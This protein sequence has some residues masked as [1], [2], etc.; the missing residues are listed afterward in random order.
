M[1]NIKGVLS[2]YTSGEFP[3]CN[4]PFHI[5]ETASENS[6]SRQG[7]AQMFHPLKPEIYGALRD[8]Y[9]ISHA[10]IQRYHAAILF[11]RSSA[12]QVPLP[13]LKVIAS[14]PLPSESNVGTGTNL[15]DD[16]VFFSFSPKNGILRKTTDSMVE[17]ICD[18]ANRWHSA[19]P[20]ID[21]DEVRPNRHLPG[22]IPMFAYLP[23][24]F[25]QFLK[26]GP[27][28]AAA[29]LARRFSRREFWELRYLF[30]TVQS[31]SDEPGTSLGHVAVCVIS[32]ES[33]TIDFLCS[34]GD[35]GIVRDNG[36][37]C[38]ETIIRLLVE[39]LGDEPPLAQRFNPCDWKL[40]TERS[41]L[42]DKSKPDCGMYMI[43]NIMCV[44]FGWDLSYGS[45]QEHELQCR[46][47]RLVSD[48]QS[49]GFKGYNHA[50]DADNTHYYPLNDIKPPDSLTENFIPILGYPGLMIYETLPPEVYC[51]SP[52]YYGCPDKET[53]Y[54]HCNRNK[55]F[56]PSFDKES[57]SGP[58]ISFAKLLSWVE[59]YDAARERDVAPFPRPYIPSGANGNRRWIP[60]DD[61]V[62]PTGKLW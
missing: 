25:E 27:E 52:I 40:R 51:R 35:R 49:G 37:Q 33:K 61:A 6:I 45:R 47:F 46:R 30:I 38:V 1:M 16:D 60:P 54:K 34:G 58:N 26:Q 17:F 11:N 3:A 4:A 31:G 23:S 22:T 50:E 48:L 36:S 8:Q 56:Y 5:P 10:R 14:T 7:R 42:Q 39:Y 59:R 15:Y 12:T 9:L 20:S 44:A 53:L 55:R 21:P 62:W 41:E 13:E 24:S 29:E 28:Q 19:L 57:I 2:N 43:S 32:P 18:Y